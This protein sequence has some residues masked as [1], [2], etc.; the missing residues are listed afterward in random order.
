MKEEYKKYI[1]CIG[2]EY[3]DI[4]NNIGFEA[5]PNQTQ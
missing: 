1:K 5:K 4:L 3:K 2:S